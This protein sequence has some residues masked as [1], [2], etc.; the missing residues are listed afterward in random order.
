MSKTRI[1]TLAK[2]LG[3]DNAQL[4]AMLDDLDVKYKSVSSMMEFILH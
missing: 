3:M 1:Y 4:L 2:E